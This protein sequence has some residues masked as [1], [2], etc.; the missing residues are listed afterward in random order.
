VTTMG[1]YRFD[2]DSC[3]MYLEKIHPG[4]TVEQVKDS[5]KWDI[6]ISP[7]LVETEHPTVEQVTILRTLDPTGLYLGNGRATLAGDFEAFMAMFEDSYEPIT[8][9]MQ[10][11]GL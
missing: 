4:I 1:I 3:E 2:R 9:L 6:Q 5:I 11:K 7:Q 10:S 8:K